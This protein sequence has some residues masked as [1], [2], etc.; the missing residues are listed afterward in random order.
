MD[1]SQMNIFNAVLNICPIQIKYLKCFMFMYVVIINSFLVSG[2][3]DEGLQ[4]GVL[5]IY[6]FRVGNTFSAFFSQNA[7]YFTSGL[8]FTIKSSN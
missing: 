8:I 6:L 1:E 2:S 5:L 4:I 7:M 3:N